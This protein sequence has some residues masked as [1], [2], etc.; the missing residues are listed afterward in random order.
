MSF[1]RECL[2]AFRTG[3][4][5]EAIRLL[6]FVANPHEL[7]VRHNQQ[8]ILHY[9]SYHGW[10]ELVMLL[11]SKY[12]FNPMCKDRFGNTSLHI[13][14]HQ[15][16][17]LMLVMYLINE[18]RCDPISTNNLG[19]TILNEACSNNDIQIVH[20]LTGELRCNLMSKSNGGNTP[21]HEACRRY[22][23]CI[24]IIE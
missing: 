24:F 4:K 9:T 6:P 3:Q 17:N 12:Q 15:K 16:G 10:I 20:Y 19:Y 8:T 11:I 18:C 22:P 7:I 14:C 1:D 13:A 5:H 2:W 23:P 21:L